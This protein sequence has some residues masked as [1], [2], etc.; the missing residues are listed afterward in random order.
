MATEQEY[1]VSWRIRAVRGGYR[2]SGESTVM[3]E[4]E[5]QARDRAISKLYQAGHVDYPS[6]V[7]ITEVRL[8]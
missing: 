8:K 6:E 2:D 1:I 4:N 3:A 7:E 5:Q